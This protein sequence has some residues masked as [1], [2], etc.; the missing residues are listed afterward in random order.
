MTG[1]EPVLSLQDVTVRG[2][3]GRELVRHVTLSVSP[4]ELLAVVGETG[5]GKTTLAKVMAGVLAPSAGTVRVCGRAPTD[6]EAA[7]AVGWLMQDPENQVVGATVAEDAAFGPEQ[8]GLEPGEVARRVALALAE[9]GL[10]GRE[11]WHPHALSGGQRA[12]LA[13]AG[14]LAMEPA[15]LVL[16]EPTAMLDPRSRRKV[17]EV[18]ARR[19]AR[20]TATVWITHDLAEAAHA[21]RVA[22]LRGGEM[23]LQGPPRRVL[24][25]LADL[26]AGL[27]PPPVVRLAQALGLP[28]EP[29]TEEELLAHLVASR[30]A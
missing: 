20:G 7:G 19:R 15:V 5:S 30:G 1:A 10:S 27:V 28:G 4:G 3:G 8:A 12:L 9:V 26:D 2:A 17:A 18:V 13:L 23:L 14:L 6:A 24:H 29:V 22:V 21:D 11:D 16:D 25:A